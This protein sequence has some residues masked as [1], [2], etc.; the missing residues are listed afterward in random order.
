MDENPKWKFFWKFFFL[1]F[2]WFKMCSETSRINTKN[3]CN[4][5]ILKILHKPDLYNWL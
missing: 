4:I 5:S 2:F 1:K 3:F